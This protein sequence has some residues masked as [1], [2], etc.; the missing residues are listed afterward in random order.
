MSAMTRIC[1]VFK[2]GVRYIFFEK[3]RQARN[4]LPPSAP[5]GHTS[6]GRTSMLLSTSKLWKT[7]K[8]FANFCDWLTT[9]S[10]A[11]DDRR[12]PNKTHNQEFLRQ[13]PKGRN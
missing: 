1:R 11:D 2:L 5:T 10:E 3:E 6:Q 13:A 7:V 9:T 12:P 8:Q 4:V